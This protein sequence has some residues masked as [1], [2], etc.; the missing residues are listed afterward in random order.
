MAAR[1]AADNTIGPLLSLIER[2]FDLR[3]NIQSEQHRRMVCQ[4]YDEKRQML[5]WKL[6]EAAA[7]AHEDYAKAVLISEAM[8]LMLREIDPWPR[9]NKGKKQ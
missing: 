8:R 7:L 9:R 3:L 2:R 6:G 1:G 5:L 4:H